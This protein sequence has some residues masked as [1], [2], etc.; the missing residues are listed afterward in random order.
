MGQG[1]F[2]GTDFM[3]R[4][5]SIGFDEFNARSFPLTC[6]GTAMVRLARRET[7]LTPMIASPEPDSGLAAFSSYEVGDT[8]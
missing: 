3:D 4:T 8:L 6:C 5:E 7:I 1:M 2:L